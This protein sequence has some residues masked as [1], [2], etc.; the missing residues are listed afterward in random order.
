MRAQLTGPAENEHGLDADF[1]EWI[2]KV[3]PLSEPIK[4]GLMLLW[5]SDDGC[6]SIRGVKMTTYSLDKTWQACDKKWNRQCE[7]GPGQH[8]Q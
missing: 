4:L 2:G 5:L 7:V 3:L 1:V 8:G 6:G